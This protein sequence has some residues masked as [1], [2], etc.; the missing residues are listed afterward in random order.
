MNKLQVLYQDNE[1]GQALDVTTITSSPKWTT[2]R[3]GSPSSFEF[4]AVMDVGWNNGSI[5]M[6]MNGEEGVFHGY[7]FSVKHSE[8]G[9]VS[10]K[11]YDQLRYLKNK[12]TYVVKGLR[13]D[14]LLLRIAEDYKLKTGVLDN[15]G[16]VIPSM[17]EDGKTLFDILLK[18]IDLTLINTGRMYVLWDDFGALRITS[19]ES[20]KTDLVVGDGSLAT[21][22][23]HTNEIDS[24][25]ATRVKL[26]KDNK[27]TGRRE[28]YIVQDSGNMSR[29]GWLQH[30]E[31]VDE[32][33]NP[34][35]IAAMG[36]QMLELRNKPKSTFE[37]DGLSDLSVRAGRGVF[38][39]I[40][41]LGMS[42]YYLVDEA[43]HDLAAGTMSLK[44]KV[45]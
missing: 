26:V 9:T 3:A 13:A 37:L 12:D 15:T 45:A 18:A 40:A 14:Q 21:G 23:T 6:V 38:V 31:K 16:Y 1:T 7:I 20:M 28:V 24:Y 33:M 41:E 32:G 36:E 10:V 8:K 39:R 2:K 30:Y 42:Q 43:T 27:S 5:V 44:L 4:E 11:A 34:A 35:Q 25:T 29:W 22:Y 17:V 19:A